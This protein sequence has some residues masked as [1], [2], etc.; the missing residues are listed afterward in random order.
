MVR[1]LTIALDF[2]AFV[3]IAGKTASFQSILRPVYTVVLAG[4]ILF[5]LAEPRLAIEQGTQFELLGAWRGLTTQ[6]NGLGSLAAIGLIL[7][8]DGG[9]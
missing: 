2:F 5:V 8:P 6:K 1:A 3:L 4:S 7:G 9:W